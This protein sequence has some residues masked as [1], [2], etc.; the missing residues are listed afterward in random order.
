[1]YGGISLFVSVIT[2]LIAFKPFFFASSLSAGLS[3]IFRKM[4]RASST[5]HLLRPAV[6]AANS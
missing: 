1:M 4:R 5:C 6:F 2:G 3:S